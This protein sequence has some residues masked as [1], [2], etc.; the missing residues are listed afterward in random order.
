[1]SG[2]RCCLDGAINLMRGVLVRGKKCQN[3][4]SN[5]C[6]RSFW[7][8]SQEFLALHTTIT[9]AP[10]TVT[11]VFD[12]DTNCIRFARSC[13]FSARTV[14]P[15]L[16]VFAASVNCEFSAWWGRARLGCLIANATDGSK[17]TLSF[18]IDR[19]NCTCEFGF[20]EAKFED[21][22]DDAA[23]LEWV[24]V[25]DWR[26]SNST[27]AKKSCVRSMPI[28]TWR[29]NKNL[30]ENNLCHCENPRKTPRMSET[31]DANNIYV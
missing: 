22:D 13:S 21:K 18:S 23:T 24:I 25:I 1:M 30:L 28:A 19:E 20:C 7:V 11:H 12:S 3:W 9:W 2:S 31:W 10:W 14:M 15:P 5:T 26:W 4:R 8:W 16:I 6:F 29:T 17:G 27:A